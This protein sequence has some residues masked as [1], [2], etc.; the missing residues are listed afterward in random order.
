M[1][2]EKTL[3]KHPHKAISMYELC[4]LSSWTIFLSADIN[5]ARIAFFTPLEVTEEFIN[6]MSQG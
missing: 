6:D 3:K 4:P 1:Q 5:S 2:K